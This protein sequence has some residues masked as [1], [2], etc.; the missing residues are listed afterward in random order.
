MEKHFYKTHECLIRTNLE[1]V[2]LKLLFKR[3]LTSLLV[4]L[5]AFSIIKTVSSMF[6]KQS[7]NQNNQLA[8]AINKVDNNH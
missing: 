5:I 6:K 2:N 1:K 8:L 3:R 7:R 4:N